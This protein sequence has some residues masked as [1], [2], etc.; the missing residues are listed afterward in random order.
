MA[1][2]QPQTNGAS[3][4]NAS[5][6][7]PNTQT[8]T[9]SQP[10]PATA[11]QPA[12]QPTTAS[13]PRPRDARLVELLLTSQGVTAYEQRVPLLLLDFAYRHT[14]SI[15]SDALHL[16]GDPHVTQAGSKPAASSGAIATAPG[17][18]AITANAVKLAISARLSYQFRGG[19]SGGGISKEYM[20]ELARE[21]NKVTL[22]RIVP[23]EWGVRLPSERFVLSGTSWG[24]KEM[25][26]GDQGDDMDDD[27]DDDED[28]G[29]DGVEGGT[30]EDVFG[31][32]VDEEMAEDG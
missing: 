18:A 5:Q 12:P 8:T 14:S 6:T 32:D 24:L 27:D 30:V 29:G 7:V 19:S 20:Q 22:P 11:A 1:S 10:A 2:S 15:L 4:A 9:A 21:R 25:W 13:D 16:S 17:E 26:E 3:S 31:D 23:N 28:V